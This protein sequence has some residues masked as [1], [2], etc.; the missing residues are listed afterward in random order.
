MVNITVNLKFFRNSDEKPELYAITVNEDINIEQLKE[1]VKEILNIPG[2]CHNRC[3]HVFLEKEFGEHLRVSPREIPDKDLNLIMQNIIDGS[4][5]RI[6]K[7]T[8]VIIALGNE[9]RNYCFWKSLNIDE[10]KRYVVN[11]FHLSNQLEKLTYDGNEIDSGLIENY[12]IKDGD[13]I[14]VIKKN[15]DKVRA[16]AGHVAA[17]AQWAVN[18]QDTVQAG[19]EESVGVG[20]L[21]KLDEGLQKTG[22][23]FLNKIPGSDKRELGSNIKRA[24]GVLIPGIGVGSITYAG[25]ELGLYGGRKKRS[26][27]KRRSR[28]K[29]STR[30]ISHKRRIKRRNKRTN[31][32]KRRS[33]R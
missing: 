17:G 2:T 25:N 16:S 19:A 27:K 20:K 33:R 7:Y 21:A 23:F 8:S 15:T 4:T 13:T 28:R 1:H 9:K 31:V 29:R 12:D 11:R 26:T 30:T 3:L 10:L 6:F 32:R 5:I 14:T 22:E 24:T 18:N